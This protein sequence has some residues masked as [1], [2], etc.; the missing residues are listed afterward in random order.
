MKNQNVTVYNQDIDF[1]KIRLIS[2]GL[3]EKDDYGEL[4][5]K[6]SELKKCDEKFSMTIKSSLRFSHS[7]SEK[8][9]FHAVRVENEKG[10]VFMVGRILPEVIASLSETSSEILQEL[11]IDSLT[12]T[13]QA[14]KFSKKQEKSSKMLSASTELSVVTA[15]SF[16]A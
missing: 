16:G 1:W 8:L 5:S 14:T 2:E 12:G 9:I 3:V 11:K 7:M 13:L 4:E 10:E 6:I 15:G